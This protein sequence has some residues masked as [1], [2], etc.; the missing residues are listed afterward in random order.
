M[1]WVI[2]HLFLD[3]TAALYLDS[4]IIDWLIS[5]KFNTRKLSITDSFTRYKLEILLGIRYTQNTIKI[6]T[7]TKP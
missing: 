4:S 1:V 3:A 2:L 5:A 6:Q 7:K